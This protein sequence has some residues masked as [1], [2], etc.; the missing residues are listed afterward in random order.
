MTGKINSKRKR[1]WPWV[2]GAIVL[3]LVAVPMLMGAVARGAA[4]AQPPRSPARSSPLPSA[5]SRRAQLLPATWR[6]SV[7]L[8]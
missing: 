4:A 7:R 5:T 3:A 1:R 2:V 8:V 6:R